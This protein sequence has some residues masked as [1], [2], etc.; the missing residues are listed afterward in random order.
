MKKL[1]V[2]PK[3][4]KN[5]PKPINKLNTLKSMTTP[6]LR[7]HKTHIVQPYFYPGSDIARYGV[8]VE[9]DPNESKQASFLKELEGIATQNGVDT[10]GHTDEEMIFIKFQTKDAV[11]ICV[12]DPKE[13]DAPEISLESEL[14]YSTNVI[15]QFDLNLYYNTKERKKGFNFCPKKVIL[16]LDKKTMKLVEVANVRTSKNSSS[17]SK[18]TINRSSGSE[19]EQR[20]KPNLGNK[21]R[22]SKNPGKVQKT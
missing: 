17:R 9:I 22:G 7:V 15:I 18:P 1:L 13:E 12:E 14:P 8:V 11:K 6:V 21:L 5:A 16:Q 2:K 10:I 3:S 19:L 4:E 20:N